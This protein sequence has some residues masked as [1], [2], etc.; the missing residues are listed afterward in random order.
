MERQLKKRAAFNSVVGHFYDVEFRL[1]EPF[2][3][4]IVQFIRYL[5]KKKKFVY[6]KTQKL[7]YL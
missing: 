4:S 5:K 2:Q 3:L 1:P 7:G 6:K